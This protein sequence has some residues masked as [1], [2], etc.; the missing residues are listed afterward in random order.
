M[1]GGDHGS[2]GPRVAGV[3]V[4]LRPRVGA[5]GPSEHRR[6]SHEEVPRDV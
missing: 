3:P 4:L 1:Q 5:V 6:Q 2:G